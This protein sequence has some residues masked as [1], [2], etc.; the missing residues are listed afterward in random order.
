MS[1]VVGSLALSPLNH[2]SSLS[3]CQSRK[4]PA[5]AERAS[6]CDR[7]R[8]V[9]LR[10]RTSGQVGARGPRLQNW[11]QLEATRRAKGLET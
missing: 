9:Q 7:Y 8:A 3:S 11:G 1:A 5:A 2:S 6:V 10:W 4:E